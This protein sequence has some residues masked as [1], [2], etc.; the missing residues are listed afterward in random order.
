VADQDVVVW[1]RRHW[2]D[3]LGAAVP[4][5][6]LRQV[7]MSDL[8]GGV[9]RRSPRPMV[10]GYIYCDDV[11]DGD[12]SHSCLHGPPP[13]WIKVVVVAKDN[14]KPLMKALR[15]RAASTSRSR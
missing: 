11:V 2:N 13:H 1:V 12:L 9:A 14:P 15:D 6:A 8:S 7:H 3:T 10:T 5:A 4:L